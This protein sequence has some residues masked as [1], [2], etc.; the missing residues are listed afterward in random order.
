MQVAW[1]GY[2]S[3]EDRVLSNYY[4]YESI[5]H[6]HYSD[7]A[8]Y[9]SMSSLEEQ[10]ITSILG[11]TAFTFTITTTITLRIHVYNNVVY[12]IQNNHLFPNI[13][14]GYFQ[15]VSSTLVSRP[16]LQVTPIHL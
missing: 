10:S 7:C 11:V 6:L 4:L 12:D 9:K 2:L 3:D 1:G 16:L 13:F 8:S 5:Y 15:H 14:S